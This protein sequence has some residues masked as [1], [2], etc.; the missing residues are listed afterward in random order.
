[1]LHRWI[2]P[3]LLYVIYNL[4]RLTWRIRVV[5]SEKFSQARK[6]KRRM[7]YAHWHGSIPGVLYLLKPYNV[8]TMISGSKDGTLVDTIAR[9]LGGKTV[10]GSSTRGGATALKGILRLAN[11][12]Y[13]PGIAIDGPKGP[14]GKVKPGVLEISRVLGAEI[15][16]LTVTCN[17]AWVFEKA[18]D[19]TFLP[20]PFAKVV[21][22]WGD[23]AFTVGRNDD[24]RDPKLADRL[25]VAMANAEQHVRNLIAAP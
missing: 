23:P 11:E 4:L 12:G 24:P 20:K 2:L 13:N 1:M 19:K 7:I 17:R 8:V 3:L 25:E 5:E 15:H 9:W 10:R 6:E 18:W 16:P 22:Y 14:R 21:V